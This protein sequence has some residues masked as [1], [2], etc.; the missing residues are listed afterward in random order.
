[1]PTD[2]LLVKI[3][4]IRSE[5]QLLFDVKPSA[6][7]RGKLDAAL[8][9]LRGMPDEFVWRASHDKLSTESGERLA[10]PNLLENTGKGNFDPR[11][12]GT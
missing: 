2:S 3:L 11:T 1:M 9:Y 8:R 7:L 5:A 10:P 12:T 4:L 6:E